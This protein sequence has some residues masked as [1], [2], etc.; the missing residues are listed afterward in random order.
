[1]AKKL[2]LISL[3]LVISLA[4]FSCLTKDDDSSTTPATAVTILGKWNWHSISGFSTMHVTI[5]AEGIDTT[6]R[7]DTVVEAA[8]ENYVE[9]RADSTYTAVVDESRFDLL[10]GDQLL[11]TPAVMQ[12]QT[13]TGRWWISGA[14]LFITEPAEWGTGVDTTEMYTNLSGTTL[15]LTMT[16]TE[17]WTEG[18]MSMS[19]DMRITITTIKE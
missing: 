12:N 4:L 7:R 13:Q 15:T 8:P 2:L 10:W 11:K 17:S 16:E 6:I 3:S 1:M 19:S 5:P 14:L 18:G 9:F